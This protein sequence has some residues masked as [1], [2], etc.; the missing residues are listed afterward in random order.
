MM[1]KLISALSLMLIFGTGVCFAEPEIPNLV[2]TWTVQAEGTVLPKSSVP[3]ELTHYKGDFSAIS[4]DIVV[5]QQQGRIFHGTF[6]SLKAIENIIGV[7]GWDN[8]SIYIVDQDGF[9]DGV[10]VNN[11]KIS[12]IYRHVSPNDSVVAAGTCIRKK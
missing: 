9:I 10:I 3:W 8:K 2:G 6:K 7:I 11:D 1:K 12:Y 5:S 4:A